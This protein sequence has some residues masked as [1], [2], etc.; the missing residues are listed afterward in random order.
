M[1]CGH[2]PSQLP[3][4]AGFFIQPVTSDAISHRP[5]HGTGPILRAG[6]QGQQPD[7]NHLLRRILIVKGDFYCWGK[8]D[9]GFSGPGQ[10]TRELDPTTGS[11]H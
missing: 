7:T 1:T 4:L 6:P 8:V 2:L 11:I 9:G 5:L 3:T 10:L